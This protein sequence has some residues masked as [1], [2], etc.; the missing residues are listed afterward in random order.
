MTVQHQVYC[1]TLN[2][3]GYDVVYIGIT[4]SFIKKGISNLS[5]TKPFIKLKKLY[6]A[7]SYNL[8]ISLIFYKEAD[9]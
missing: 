8:Y 3:N 7:I 6:I 2:N 1:F 4:W 5:R 9:V